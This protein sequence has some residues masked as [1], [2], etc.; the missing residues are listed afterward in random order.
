MNQRILL[1]SGFSQVFN[2]KPNAAMETK[3][4]Q[5]I[6]EGKAECMGRRY[7]YH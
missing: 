2:A 7:G 5:V 3:S 6:T 1:S 4:L